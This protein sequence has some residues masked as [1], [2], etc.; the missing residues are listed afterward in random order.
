VP[1]SKGGLRTMVGPT[2]VS[3]TIEGAII[4]YEGEEL[5][6]VAAQLQAVMKEVGNAIHAL[7]DEMTR[8]ERELF[9]LTLLGHGQVQVTDVIK[10]HTKIKEL[11]DP[12]RD[13]GFT[14]ERLPW[15]DRD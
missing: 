7:H 10:I 12:L 2:L 1:E 4:S 15:E 9:E 6:K 13:Q 3:S 14:H 11:L 8:L 5:E